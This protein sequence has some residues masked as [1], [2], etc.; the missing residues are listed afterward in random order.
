MFRIN[1]HNIEPGAYSG[2]AGIIVVVAV[3]TKVEKD[4]DIH[5]LPEPIVLYRNSQSTIG[6][7]IM[8]EKE[9]F[10]LHYKLI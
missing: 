3:V 7:L 4:G 9:Y 10:L 5:L 8:I 2:P 6:N 1:E